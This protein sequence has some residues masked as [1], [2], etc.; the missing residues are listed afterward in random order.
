MKFK[1]IICAIMIT[2]VALFCVGCSNQNTA[3]ISS[4]KSERRLIRL[5]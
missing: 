4:V 2:V 1:K 5:A 3:N